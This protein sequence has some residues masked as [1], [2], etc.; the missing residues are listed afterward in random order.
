[1]LRIRNKGTVQRI[2]IPSDALEAI[3]RILKSNVS[4]IV[5]EAVVK[6]LAGGWCCVCHDI[7]GYMVT[8][9]VGD[10]KQ[11]GQRIEKYCDDCL[12]KVYERD[13]TFTQTPTLDQS[14][15][16]NQIG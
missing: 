2:K 5:K 7:P 8:Y 1:V 11:A 14:S 3:Q 16:N 13:L 15:T 4:E 10:E 12:K 6:R 9:D